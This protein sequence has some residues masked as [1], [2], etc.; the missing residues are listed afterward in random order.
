LIDWFGEE[1]FFP[2]RLFVRLAQ[3]ISRRKGG[4]ADRTSPSLP[5]SHSEQYSLAQRLYWYIR[6]LTVAFSAW[7][8][9]VVSKICPASLATHAIFVF[10]KKP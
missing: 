2:D 8:E 10:R 3:A 7:S 9:P 1:F 5:G 4:L 6:G